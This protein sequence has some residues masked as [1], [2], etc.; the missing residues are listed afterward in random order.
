MDEE[1]IWAAFFR[2]ALE[3]AKSGAKS[4]FSWILRRKKLTLE[5][6]KQQARILF[7]DD[8]SFE[9]L[10]TN[11]RDAGWNVRQIDDLKNFDSEDIKLSDIIFV[12]YKDV[13]KSLTPSEEGI[14]LLKQLKI[15]YPDKHI[16]F[17]SGYAGFI[18]GN[19]IHNIADGWIQK[20]S[21]PYV[22]IERIEKAA[23]SIYEKR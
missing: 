7:I 18:P 14:G 19:E 9:S 21:D 5:E 1:K 8:E 6:I 2:V 10:L 20:H 22:Y 17:Y 12:D 3:E 16:I 4:I 11:I 23:K 15:R 13:G